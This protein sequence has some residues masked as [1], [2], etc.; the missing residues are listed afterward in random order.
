MLVLQD[1]VNDLLLVALPLVIER[2]SDD[3]DDVSAVAAA[4]LIP[5]A[6]EIVAV[7]PNQVADIISKLWDLLL[8]QDDLAAAC[9][10]FMGLLAALLSL[11]DTKKYIM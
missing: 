4:S 2:L 3:V 7:T 11:P 5:V 1:L 8:D 6:E 9:N 10:N